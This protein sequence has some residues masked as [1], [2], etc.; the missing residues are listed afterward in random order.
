MIERVKSSQDV[1]AMYHR[2]LTGTEAFL[3][4]LQIEVL[5]YD[6]GTPRQN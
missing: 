3:T 1:V 6:Q 2:K 5:F 4:L